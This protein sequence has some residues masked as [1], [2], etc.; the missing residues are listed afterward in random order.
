MNQIDALRSSVAHA[1]AR[2]DHRQ[3][4]ALGVDAVS[5]TLGAAEGLLEEI[6]ELKMTAARG[7]PAG[8]WTRQCGLEGNPEVMSIGGAACLRVR[9]FALVASPFL[10]RTVEALMNPDGVV[11]FFPYLPFE[12]PN[13][14]PGSETS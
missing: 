9:F 1:K 10:D 6:E 8:T 12:K 5:L 13:P 14:Q 2:R 3:D 7:M 11:V 4:D